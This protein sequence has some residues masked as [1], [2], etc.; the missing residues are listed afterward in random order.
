MQRT[1]VRNARY[2]T[3]RSNPVVEIFDPA[4][5]S[6]DQWFSPALSDRYRSRHRRYSWAGDSWSR[7]R[8]GH[9]NTRPGRRFRRWPTDRFGR[10]PDLRLKRTRRFVPALR[11]PKYNCSFV[12]EC[13]HTHTY[14][15]TF[16]PMTHARRL[17]RR[18][19]SA[20]GRGAWREP[21]TCCRHI[22]GPWRWSRPLNL[23]LAL[24]LS[25]PFFPVT[26]FL[27]DPL[28]FIRYVELIL[29][30]PSPIFNTPNMWIIHRKS[31]TTI[32]RLT[33]L[34]TSSS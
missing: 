12:C 20:R 5:C 7:S 18:P 27:L 28:L 17:D 29:G 31:I 33:F 11:V 19:L 1:D 16:P 2:L 3:S 9:S 23:A 34:W 30:S 24:V 15:H 26:Y 25:F 13:V 14:T 6:H 22:F 10:V 8:V 32:S 21:R 4:R